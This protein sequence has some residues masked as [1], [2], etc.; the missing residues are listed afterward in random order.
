[1]LGLLLWLLSHPIAAA[2]TSDPNVLFEARRAMPLVA[3]IQLPAALAYIFDGIFLGARDFR[4]LG[5]AM[6]FCVLPATAVL[7]FVSSKFNLGLLTLW[8]ASGTLLLARVAILSWR[9]NSSEVYRPVCVCVCARARVCV[10][11]CVCVCDE[12][13]L[14]CIEGRLQ[15]SEAAAEG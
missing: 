4:F 1:M 2:F 8:M 14:V 3:A 9:Y 7:L 5:I 12:D 10:C 11:V 13:A 6:M 15:D